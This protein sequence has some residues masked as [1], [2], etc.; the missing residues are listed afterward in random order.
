MAQMAWDGTAG[1]GWGSWPWMAKL[2]CDGSAGL[3]WHSGSVRAQL[4]W[5]STSGEMA[6][7]CCEL[8]LSVQI[9]QV[10]FIDK[11][12]LGFHIKVKYN[13]NC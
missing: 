3:R 2:A 6:G 11:R 5:D 12:V 13:W 9:E 4:G 8:F 1:L 10:I 7:L